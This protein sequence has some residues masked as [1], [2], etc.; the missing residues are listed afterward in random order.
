M[1]HPDVFLQVIF[2][3]YD[4]NLERGLEIV[5][6]TG[7]LI[8]KFPWE[9]RLSSDPVTLPTARIFFK[10]SREG[11]KVRVYKNGC[12]FVYP[13]NYSVS[14]AEP[15]R[16]DFIWRAHSKYFSVHIVEGS[17]PD[18]E[19]IVKEA[20]A[21]WNKPEWN[22]G[23]VQFDVGGT[24]FPIRIYI[25]DNPDCGGYGACA[26]LTTRYCKVEAKPSTGASAFIHELGHCMNMGHS[27]DSSSF[28]CG[29]PAPVSCDGVTAVYFPPNERFWFKKINS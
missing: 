9:G 10:T 23:A 28:M 29:G 1:T 3:C 25:R 5:D 26:L 2:P 17:N 7:N 11:L 22:E 18:V 14:S 6:E 21:W 19:Q 12:G 4:C 16:P 15:P 8:Q 20:V 24:G 27:M 13:L